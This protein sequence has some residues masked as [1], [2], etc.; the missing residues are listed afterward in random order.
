MMRIGQLGGGLEGGGGDR[1]CKRRVGS[2]SNLES[3]RT[4]VVA[5]SVLGGVLNS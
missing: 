1:S 2:K 5:E 4:G 3:Q